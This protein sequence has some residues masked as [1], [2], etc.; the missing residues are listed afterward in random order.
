[1]RVSSFLLVCG[2]WEQT[3]VVRLGREHLYLLSHLAGLELLLNNALGL[4]I[5]ILWICMF[6]LHICMSTICVP[7]ALE[8][9]KRTL[10]PLELELWMIVGHHVGSGN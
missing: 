9:Q 10:C 3:Q 2:S 7:G 5:F 8:I 6:C 4:F 1:M